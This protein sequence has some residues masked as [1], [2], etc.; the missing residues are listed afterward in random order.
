MVVAELQGSVWLELVRVIVSSAYIGV[1]VRRAPAADDCAP[2]HT[3]H[4]PRPGRG[5]MI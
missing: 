1:V 2:V 3:S 5:S 4:D